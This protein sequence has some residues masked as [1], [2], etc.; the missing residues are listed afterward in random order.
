MTIGVKKTNASMTIKREKKNESSKQGCRTASSS[1][2]SSLCRDG[3]DVPF[4]RLANRP[5]QAHIPGKDGTPLRMNA[6]QVGS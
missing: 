3:T 1:T 2:W 5:D 6:S 4:P